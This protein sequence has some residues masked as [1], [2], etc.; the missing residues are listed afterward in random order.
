MFVFWFSSSPSPEN[1]SRVS[2]RA[3]RAVSMSGQITYQSSLYMPDRA[4]MALLQVAALWAFTPGYCLLSK[5]RCT[6]RPNCSH[7]AR[8]RRY[9]PSRSRGY[10]RR[11]SRLALSIRSHISS[12]AFIRPVP[13]V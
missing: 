4:R 5:S 11:S 7:L 1:R 12:A 6:F 9:I 2:R 3:S 13:V 10:S 8:A